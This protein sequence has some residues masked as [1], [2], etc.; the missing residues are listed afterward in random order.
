MGEKRSWN[1][2][3]W[4]FFTDAV[5]E[6]RWRRTAN[7][8]ELVGC[9][10]ESYKNRGDCEANAERYGWEKDKADATVV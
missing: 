4:H 1:K 5:G 3:H 7:N 10:H 6:W 8:N 9:S 2:D